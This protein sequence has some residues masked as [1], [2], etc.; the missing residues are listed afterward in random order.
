MREERGVE[1]DHLSINRWAI[2]FLPLLEKVSKRIEAPVVPV[3]MSWERGGPWV[4][5]DCFPPV[6]GDSLVEFTARARERGW[7]VG[8]FSNGTRWVV[9][10]LW[11]GYDGMDYFDAHHA[12]QG[13]SRTFAGEL[14]AEQWDAAWRP[15][16]V[17]CLGARQTME[18]AQDYVQ[19]VI[20]YGIDWIQFLDQN[21]GACTFPCYSHEHGHP[22]APGRWMTEAMLELTAFFRQKQAEAAD[23]SG[24][25]RKLVFS[26][27][28]PVTE[29]LLQSFQICDIRVVPPNHLAA[30]PWWTNS[31]PLY[32]FLFH[33]YILMQGGF[34]HGADPHHLA[35]RN[36]YNFV[37]GEIPGAVLKGDGRLLNSDN[38]GINW[39]PWEP[40]IG[41][42]EEALAMLHTTTAMR[43]GPGKPYLVFGKMLPPAA[44]TAQ[45]IEWRQDRTLNSVPAVFH[46]AWQSPDGTF[47]VVLAN[48]TQQPQS[49]TVTDVRLQA[50]RVR[51]QLAA[52]AIS[53]IEAMPN[54]ESITIEIPPLGCALIEVG[55]AS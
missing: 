42:D 28:G 14:W 17:C 8:T 24:G 33:E 49:V 11:S 5:P 34:G 55:G 18:T 23:S 46:A 15:S 40:H 37:V 51:V 3:I 12:E 50:A 36:A 39:A 43:R 30:H 16:F 32:Q 26:V 2:R 44:V 19:R 6:G 31:I 9:G 38:P 25:A 48:W 20:D 41:D 54:G 47:A 21:V 53:S 1:V 4:Y 45:M 35:I 13:I 52:P 10:H 7:H 22:P 27:E 29:Y